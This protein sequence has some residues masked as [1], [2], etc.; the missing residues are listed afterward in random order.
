MSSRDIAIAMAELG[1]ESLRAHMLRDPI[2]T[3]RHGFAV[4]RRGG[5][6]CFSST[7]LDA[8]VFNHVSGYG[9][10]A[11]ASQRAIDAVRRYYDQ[12][13]GDANFEVMSGAVSRGDRTLLE[14]NGFREKTVL[15]QCHVRTSA[16]P[17]R[18]HDVKDLSIA[19]ARPVDALTYA[20][21][22]TKGFGGGG[23]IA[24][25]FERG[26]ARQ[27]RKDRRVGAF[28]G[29]VHGKP[30]ATGVII[31][32]PNIAGLYSGSVLRH[33]RGRGIQNAMIAA[34]I[35]HGWAK[36][37]RVFYSWSDPDNSSARNLRDEGFRTRFEMH[38]Y[39]RRK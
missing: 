4:V 12:L 6:M 38:W 13:G 22:A 36:G 1:A 17:P 18:T 37:L 8:G 15:F 21:L 11:P 29:Q 27:I 35:A 14:R 25:V 30:A 28:I 3:P 23:M 5:M 34:R 19:R 2:L 31:L 10:F 16:R 7:K 20:R 32:R 26:W 24:D 39:T 33:Y 9:T